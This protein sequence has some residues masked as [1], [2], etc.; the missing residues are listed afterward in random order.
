MSRDLTGAID[1][2]T[3]QFRSNL[4]ER[5]IGN[6]LNFTF[7]GKVNGDAM[8][9]DLNM[10]EYLTARWSAKRRPAGQRPGGRPPG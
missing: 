6:A 4:A 9:G 5:T 3:V 1:G 10:G 7:T 8:S 2:D